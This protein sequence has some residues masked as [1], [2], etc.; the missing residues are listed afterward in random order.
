MARTNPDARTHARTTHAHT[1]NWSCNNYVSLT[2]SGLD[3][4]GV[5]TKLPKAYLTFSRVVTRNGRHW[6]HASTIQLATDICMLMQWFTAETKPVILLPKWTILHGYVKCRSK[7]RIDVNNLINVFLPLRNAGNSHSKRK[8]ID[9]TCNVSTCFKQSEIQ[10]KVLSVLNVNIKRHFSVNIMQGRKMHLANGILV[11][12]CVSEV[13]DLHSPIAI[14]CVFPIT[15]TEFYHNKIGARGR[16]K[17]NNPKYPTHSDH[18][19]WADTADSD[20]VVYNN[21]IKNIQIVHSWNGWSVRMNTR[22]LTTVR[23]VQ[24][25]LQIKNNIVLHSINFFKASSTW[26]KHE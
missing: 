7:G 13:N 16:K 12:K 4:N 3:K 14:W 9:T 26:I 19:A 24:Q 6:S 21:F 5:V 22:P 8:N 18:S 2:A 17:R 10:F 25:F 20:Q 23:R 15:I 11:F 1:P